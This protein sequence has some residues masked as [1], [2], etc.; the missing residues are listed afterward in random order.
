MTTVGRFLGTP[1]YCSPEQVR[2]ETQIGP[3]SDLY[4]CGV[5][6]WEM[7]AGS[8]P[9]Q[10]DS[11]VGILNAHLNQYPRDRRGG[12]QRAPR[13][14]KDL[15]PARKPNRRPRTATA[16]LNLLR[17]R[18]SLSVGWSSAARW[19]RHTRWARNTGGALLSVLVAAAAFWSAQPVSVVPEGT[20]VGLDHQGEVPIPHRPVISGP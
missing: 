5:I 20:G 7:L 16:A 14:L 18:G 2:G 13:H 6:L 1:E 3:A 10:G 8:P 9:F 15:P 19:V 17:P 4:S 12:L 11:E